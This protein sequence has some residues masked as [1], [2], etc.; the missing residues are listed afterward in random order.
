MYLVRPHKEA[1]RHGGGLRAASL[2]YPAATT[3]WLDL[4]TGINPVPYPARPASVA[5]RSRLPDPLSLAELEHTAARFFKAQPERV[6]A[7][8][9]A[10]TIIRLLPVLLGRATVDIVGPTYGAH[11]EAWQAALLAPHIIDRERAHS[12]CADVLV[13][14]NPNNPDGYVF[15]KTELTAILRQREANGRW[16]V[17]DES[18]GECAPDSA[19][20]GVISD[21]LIVLRSF[22]KFFGLAGVRLGFAIA[23]PTFKTA[24]RTMTGDWPVSADAIA[25]GQQAYADTSWCAATLSFLEHQSR[26]LDGLL[27]S[28]GFEVV[29]G[30]SLFRLA[31]H[32]RAGEWF[33]SL[34]HRGILTR[35][36]DHTPDVLRFGLPK[37]DDFDQ[38][39]SV[40]EAGL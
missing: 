35:P 14:V 40:L 26:R 17:V 25:M 7:A 3:P 24:L 29:G 15:S 5:E 27:S 11:A 4:S 22:G 30:T 34:C 16:L 36:F 19:M 39:R 21:R 10:E 1:V 31:R 23:S 37:P 9:G 12:S 20:A 6:A 18:F 2:A 8:A 32:P 33:S 13:M 28:A 38:L